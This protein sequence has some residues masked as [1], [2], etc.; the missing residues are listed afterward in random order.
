MGPH[1]GGALGRSGGAALVFAALAS[2]CAGGGGA[3][4]G[5]GDGHGGTSG[6]SRARKLLDLTAVER[7]RLC[8]AVPQPSG[9]DGG[10]FFCP[11]GPIQVNDPFCL[12]YLSDLNPH[13]LA[14]V[15]DSEDCTRALADHPCE[16][17]VAY[18]TPACQATV[19]CSTLECHN[20]CDDRCGRP[21]AGTDQTPCLSACFDA[22]S[23]LSQQCMACLVNAATRSCG[24]V[25]FPA[26][27]SDT[28]RT[29]C[30]SD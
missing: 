25:T 9:S 11:G 29:A 22:T 8:A 24:A 28:C 4:N 15:A 1:R 19:G 14:T 23:G 3:G 21:D 20:L 5:V 12:Q 7:Q 27:T 16:V 13:C 18:A 6:L 17:S 2:A 26:T 30:G 10:I